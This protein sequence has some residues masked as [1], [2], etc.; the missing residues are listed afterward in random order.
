METK[1]GGVTTPLPLPY[2]MPMNQDAASAEPWDGLARDL[3][4]GRLVPESRSHLESLVVGFRGW[5]VYAPETRLRLY[6]D[7]LLVLRDL[8]RSIVPN[9]GKIVDRMMNREGIDDLIEEPRSP[10]PPVEQVLPLVAR[11]GFGT[12]RSRPSEASA[13]KRGAKATGRQS[14]LSPAVLRSLHQPVVPPI[15]PDLE[16]P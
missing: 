4:S 3:I 11:T 14:A 1:G 15:P 5:M 10:A 12:R 2:G 13:S 9:A 6:H 8:P 16:E 7:A